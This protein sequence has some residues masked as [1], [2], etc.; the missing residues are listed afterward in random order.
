MYKPEIF[1]NYKS[2]TF[3]KKLNAEG[4]F[5]GLLKL[6]LHPAHICFLLDIYEDEAKE[7]FQKVKNQ[8]KTK[9]I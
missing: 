7:I 1:E 9:T 2:I 4:K 3:D 5:V 6:K 8:V